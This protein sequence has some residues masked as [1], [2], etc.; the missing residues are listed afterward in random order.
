VPGADPAR[1]SQL[2]GLKLAALVR[3][4]AGADAAIV[5][6]VWPGG[7]AL[8]RN[9]EAWVLAE[10]DADRSLGRA[11]A[12]A[13]QQGAVALHLLAERSTGLLARRAALFAVPPTVWEVRDRTLVRA[14]AQPHVVPPALDPELAE[15][16]GLIES[17]GAVPVVERGVLIGE[18]D[19]LEVCRAVR[20]S[21]TGACR[22]DVGVGAHDREAFQLVHGD[23]P[24]A[25]A[26]KM[27]V[28]AVIP[29][30]RPGAEPHPLNRLGAERA[31]RAR[32]VREPSLV[33]AS[34][35]A[36]ADPPVERLNVKDA[37][38]CA[39]V[40]VQSS[41][42]PVVVVCSAGI[43]LD[44]IPWAADARACLGLADARL[45]VVLPERD[46][47]D[48]TVALA[49]ALARPAEVLSLQA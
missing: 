34:S 28:D 3:D 31:V 7:A 42:E 14:E 39:A 48:V 15:F 19:G 24:T 21:E 2:L 43:D 29:H 23:V 49:G 13:R 4:H 25:A 22:L 41:G 36:A 9:G 8:M 16:A 18:V 12:W 46:R 33:G 45:V 6:G 37:V 47:A 32:L 35:L 26:L 30:R 40:G 10:D 1:R 17:A 20:D 44:V 5:P 11:L 38:P 27:V